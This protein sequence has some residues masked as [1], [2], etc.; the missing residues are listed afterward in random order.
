MRTEAKTV[1][2]EKSAARTGRRFYCVVE[3]EDG[4]KTGQKRGVNCM[5]YEKG[6]VQ[7]KKKRRGWIRK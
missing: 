1:L 3:G 7:R 4:E 2:R 5:A 6:E